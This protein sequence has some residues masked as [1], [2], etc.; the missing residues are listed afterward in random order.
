M[1]PV[2]IL[3][4]GL[5]TRIRPL[6]EK[7]PKS[8]IEVAGRPFIEYQLKFIHKQGIRNVV[9][10]LGYQ[11]ELIEEFV[12]DGSQYGLNIS[13][14]HDGKKLLGTGGSIKKALPLLSDNFFILYGDSFLPIEFKLVENF[15][16]KNHLNKSG[17]MTIL[18]NRNKWDKSN[19]SYSNN[20]LVEYNKKNSSSEMSY[21][22]YGLSILS[23]KAFN[24][25][26][27]KKFFD[28][29]DLYHDL[30]INDQLLA[31]EVHERFYE[32]G[33]FDGI[34]DAENY[35]LKNLQ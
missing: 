24:D 35:F 16:M 20:E 6:T 7:I 8:L 2:A 29:A 33:S 19:V 3:A 25:Y 9:L 17:L 28:L 27:A 34:K 4:G 1:L 23:K 22:D 26:K 31:Y 18:S 30:S 5:A 13:Y 21:I 14:S 15:F 12:G 10:C 32:I 11:G